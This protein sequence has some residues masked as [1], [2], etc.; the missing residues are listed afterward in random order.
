[1]YRSHFIICLVLFMVFGSVASTESV[2]A[3]SALHVTNDQRIKDNTVGKV[4]LTNESTM[5]VKDVQLLPGDN[6]ALVTFTLSVTNRDGHDIDFKSYLVR[7]MSA[8]GEKFT[9]NLLQQ[10][11]V[12]NKIIPGQIQEFHFYAKVNQAAKLQDLVFKFVKL[13]FAAAGY[14]QEVGRL[15]VPQDYSFVTP[16]GAMRAFN[17]GSTPFHGKI[18]RAT[19]SY[20]DDYFL[21]LVS[22]ELTHD[23]SQGAKLP[24]LGYYMRTRSGAMYSL[25]S[26]AFTAGSA[27]QPLTTKEGTLS[28]SIPREAGAEGWQL[29]IT[30][31]VSTGESGSSVQL[32]LA[33]F[34]VPDAAAE[35]VSIGH[36]YDF[37]TKTGTYT[38]QLTSLQRLPWEDEDILAANVIIKNKSNAALPIPDLL[39][40]FRLDDAVNVEAKIVRMDKALTLQ[41]GKELNI[42]FA[43]KIPYTDEFSSISLYLQEKESD[44]TIVDLLTFK[45]NKD[46]MNM[47]FVPARET[48]TLK[49]TGQSAAYTVRADQIFHSDTSDLYAVLMDVEN[50]E[51]RFTLLRKQVAQFKAADGTVF[52][53]SITAP[54]DKVM[55]GGKALQYIWAMVPKGYKTEGMQLILGDEIPAV[56][57]NDKAKPRQEGYVNGVAFGIPEGNKVPQASFAGLAVYPYSI[58]LSH[59]GTQA[60][61][62]AGTVQLDF[63]YELS[64]NDLVAAEMRDHKLIVE[65]TDELVDSGKELIVS[66]TFDFEGTDPA[67]SLLL[68][69]HDATISYTNKDKIYKVK[70]FASYRLSVYHEFQGQK[71]LL[72]QKD[73]DWFI[74]AE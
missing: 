64:R 31:S 16:A 45:H 15:I 1:M 74:F 50:L 65:L 20:N 57:T 61:F 21:P 43:G 71:V 23:G 5:E 11:K 8:A 36:D 60:N 52:P 56:A 13:D 47:A 53:A 2:Q 38:T 58:T 28:G 62:I 6:S 32:P 44:N 68:G 55:P 59:I 37:T 42:H 22:F 34:E 69:S 14:E 46:L 12:K 66:Q 30:Q 29:I 49:D 4:N 54:S 33:F 48:K 63:D 67:K 73:L 41:P 10:D 72:A 17:I 26:S 7:L 51:K 25:Q 24:D 39:G 70:D 3:D 35:E 40:A 27:I 9:V 19:L 18:N